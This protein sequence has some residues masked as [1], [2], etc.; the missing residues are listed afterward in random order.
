[1][2]IAMYIYIYIYI[3]IPDYCPS[4]ADNLLIKTLICAQKHNNITVTVF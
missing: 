3:C 2:R 4:I 1:M